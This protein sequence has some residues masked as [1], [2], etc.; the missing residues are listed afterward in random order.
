[1]PRPAPVTTAMRPSRR[2]FLMPPHRV[3]VWATRLL[4]PEP[5]ASIRARRGAQ[6]RHGTGP[7]AESVE[8]VPMRRYSRRQVLKLSGGALAAASLAPLL[9][10][11][12]M[13]QEVPTG[14]T[15]DF[16]WWGEQEAPGL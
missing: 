15:L 11:A 1:M 10:R 14:Q 4:R 8:E 6:C 16:W 9:S 2:P 3:P 13:A 5:G 7:G 12:A